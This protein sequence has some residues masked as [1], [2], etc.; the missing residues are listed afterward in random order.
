LTD[1]DGHGNEGAEDGRVLPI[2]SSLVALGYVTVHAAVKGLKASRSDE[3]GVASDSLWSR[4]C[5]ESMREVRVD[6]EGLT[7]PQ[8]LHYDEAQTVD[9]AVGLILVSLEVVEGCSL[10]V[11]TGLV[12]AGQFLAVELITEPRSVLVA[13]LPSER[14]RF[15]DDVIRGEQ[16]LDEPQVLESSE[17]FD[18]A[19]MV[20]VSLRDERE[21][22][23]RVEEDHAFGWP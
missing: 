14:D 3:D 16:V 1:A 7:D 4:A 10:L 2:H 6:G 22:E 9:G 13:D 18:D 5:D 17:D 21:E 19:R 15:G 8:L 23:S 11:G 20:G 12:D